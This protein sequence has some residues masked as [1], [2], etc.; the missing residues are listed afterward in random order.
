MEYITKHIV[1]AF[2]SNYHYMHKM[3]L[4]FGELIVQLSLKTLIIGLYNRHMNETHF[5]T[6]LLFNCFMYELLTNILSVNH[7]LNLQST[8][9]ERLK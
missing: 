3:G 6:T 7:Q 1:C 4:A 5:W 9:H 8:N 2:I